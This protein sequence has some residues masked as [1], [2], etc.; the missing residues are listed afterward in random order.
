MLFGWAGVLGVK[1]AFGLFGGLE[2]KVAIANF[3]LVVAGNLGERSCVS[4][5][6]VFGVPLYWATSCVDMYIDI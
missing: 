5:F 6:S 3:E 4:G 1:G 2:A